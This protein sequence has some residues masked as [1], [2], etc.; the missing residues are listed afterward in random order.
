MKMQAQNNLI[1][2]IFPWFIQS[3]WTSFEGFSPF[4]G[5]NINLAMGQS[6]YFSCFFL[7][8]PVDI[9][10]PD[11]NNEN[12]SSKLMLNFVAEDHSSFESQFISV[13]SVTFWDK[14][15]FIC[16]ILMS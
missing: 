5:A 3:F 6:N 10:I 9:I 2:I 15:I 16:D 13:L 14:R 12:I 4:C 11:K 7:N 8:L 1:Q